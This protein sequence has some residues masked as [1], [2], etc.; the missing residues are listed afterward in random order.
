MPK[1]EAK[2]R[3]KQRNEVYIGIE[4][5]TRNEMN[6]RRKKKKKMCKKQFKQYEVFLKRRTAQIEK[7]HTKKNRRR[8]K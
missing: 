2:A 7:E 1:D 8:I 6:R 4:W 5:K 3:A